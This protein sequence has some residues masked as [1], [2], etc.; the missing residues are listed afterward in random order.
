MTVFLCLLWAAPGVAEPCPECPALEGFVPPEDITEDIRRM[1][2]K[3]NGGSG[4]ENVAVQQARGVIETGLYPIFANGA[5]CPQIDSEKW[6]IDYSGKRPKPA[7]HKGVDIPQPRGTPI[8]AVADGIVVGRFANDGNRKGIEVMLRHR[9][10]QTGLP[11]WT[12]SQYTHLQEMSPLPVGTEVHRGD[13]IGKT[14]N[15][16]K[17]GR[18]ERRV[19]L[20]FAILYSAVPEWSHDGEVVIPKESYFMDPNAFYRLEGPYDSPSLAALPS[21]HKGVTVPH[22]KAGGTSVPSETLR[23]WPYP[24]P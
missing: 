7:L 10:E 1:V 5:S 8:L 20:H 11:F 14:A 4:A 6:A 3:Y 12:Y 18:R 9:P 17:M 2:G 16:G 22:L 19:A 23:I 15:T 24:C 21:D 13:P